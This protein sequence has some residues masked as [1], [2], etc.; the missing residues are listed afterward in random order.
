MWTKWLPWKMV[1]SKAAKSQGFID[2]IG[3]LSRLHRLAQ[4]SE[5]TEPIELLRAGMVLHARG[6][7]NTGTI[8][9]NLDWVWPYWI[10][11][12]FDPNDES[13]IPRAFSITHVNL[14]HRNWTAVGIPDCPSMPIVDPRGLVTPLLDGWSLDCWLVS[15]KGRRL[16]PSREE[17]ANQRL[18]HDE[19]LAVETA[20]GS[21]DF[22]VKS[23]VDVIHDDH[24]VCRIQYTAT[25]AQE[26]CLVIA[27][28]PSNPE[29]VSFIHDLRFE[30]VPPQWLVDDESRVFFSR[31][32]DRVAMSCYHDGD[33][34]QMLSRSQS[35]KG[36]VQCDVGLATAA[37]MYRLSNT[38]PN[39]VTVEVPLTRHSTWPER[40]KQLVHRDSKHA[41]KP[42]AG[43]DS[44]LANACKIESPNEQWNS[45][46]RAAIANMVLHSPGDVFPGPYTYKRFWFRDAAFI[47]NSLLVANLPNRV[48][49]VIDLFPSRQ[50]RKGY[51]H[52]QE[53][54]WDSNGEAIWIVDRYFRSTGKRLT[55]S[56]IDSVIQGG[57][58]IV[59][60]RMDDSLDTSHAGLMPSGFSA[61]HLGHNDFYFW[62]DFWSV[63]GLER[64]AQIASEAGAH[65]QAEQFSEE[66]ELLRNAIERSLLATGDRR[67]DSETIPAAPDRR[68]DAGAIGSL[69]GS[70]PLQVC[71]PDD[72]RMMGTVE[73]LLN[74]CMVN[75]GFFQDMIHSGINPYLTLHLAQVLLRSGMDSDQRYVQLTQTVADLASPTGQWPE[76]V[77]PITGGGC[78]GDGQHMW[79]AAEWFMMLR[80]MFVREEGDTLIL[81]SG[82]PE[83]WLGQPNQLL[84]GPT[85]TP[86]GSVTVRVESDG[87]QIDVHWQ[88]DWHDEAP[89]IQV[90]LPGTEIQD[91]HDG[92]THCQ[93]SRELKDS[94]VRS[95]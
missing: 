75:G 90:A 51:F 49:R 68:M 38:T 47:L 94:F 82:L 1:I 79:A 18:C 31:V 73:F 26:G 81:G 28:R 65:P 5:V 10:E 77:H 29:G 83:S 71:E 89:A 53:G 34:A 88:G 80:N 72:A 48:S 2:P 66:A 30:D 78:M 41:P 46:F 76:A 60:K 69:A 55:Q 57:K 23:R 20:V 86:W 91:I 32:P 74:N 93:L 15:D 42:Q 17:Q 33:V 45:L 52:S 24:P 43:W 11:R 6:L 62:D 59:N 61:E 44:E 4:P 21:E 14:T 67:A 12:Q 9:H 63:V 36:I 70:Y 8:Q 56:M 27:L 22:S 16:Y 64:A 92:V 85:L 13:F 84:L 50:T 19:T 58:W 87:D 39:Q 25:T 3:V 7:I 54:E 95:Q 37:A 40:L 35:N